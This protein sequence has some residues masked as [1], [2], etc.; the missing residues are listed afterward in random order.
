[1]NDTSESLWSERYGQHYHNRNA[2]IEQAKLAFL[3][4]SRTDQHASPRV[5]EIG[6]GLG[7][8]FRTTLKDCLQRGVRLEYLALEHDPQS[9][10]R[11]ESSAALTGQTAVPGWQE[12][13]QVWPT[14]PCR[15]S[16]P[17]LELE[18]RLEDAASAWLPQRWATAIYLDGFS[19]A[20]NPELW[21]DEFINRLA[22][23]LSPG[24]WL[25]TYSAAGHVRRALKSAGLTIERS[26]G[27]GSK[28][29]YLRAQRPM[30]GSKPD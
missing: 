11:L 14:Q 10:A 1:M 9:T 18:V 30:Q 12:L 6:F 3:G 27:S 24:G 26:P 7:L 5:I 21:T 29:E 28:W 2:P 8:N 22:Q 4:G 20:V 13:L 15:I 25:A 23:S 16:S 19:S 17:D